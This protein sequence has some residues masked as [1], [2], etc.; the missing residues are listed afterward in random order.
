MS[1]MESALDEITYPALPLSLANEH[2]ARTVNNID[3]EKLNYR[4]FDGST[5]VS[6]AEDLTGT[7]H[8]A[9]AKA[10]NE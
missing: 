5:K 9:A 4:V 2:Q 6:P 8:V 7:E 1:T 10:A 3:L